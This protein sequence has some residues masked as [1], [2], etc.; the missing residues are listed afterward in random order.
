MTKSSRMTTA[1]HIHCCN[2][3][4]HNVEI[5]TREKL[6]KNR[7]ISS[8]I[9][10]TRDIFLIPNMDCPME[11][12]LIRKKLSGI[13]GINSLEFN[14]MQR[15]LTVEHETGLR[16]EIIAALK[17]I[18]MEPHETDKRGSVIQ[19]AAVPWKRLVL[20]GIMAFFS[21]ICDLLNGWSGY[22]SQLKFVGHNTMDILAFIL[23]IISIMLAGLSTY[24]K[25]WV[26]LSN[27]KL[28][29]NALMAVA[30]TGALLIGQFPEAAMVMVLFNISEGIEALSLNRARRAIKNLVDLAPKIMTIK[31]NDG[32]WVEMPVTQVELNTVARV[33]PGEKIGLDGTILSGQSQI[34]QAPITGESMPVE[35]SPGDAV[36][37]GTINETGSF[38]YRVTAVDSDTTLARII[39]AVEE[40]Q[41]VKA[42]M[43][44][45]VDI[46]AQYYTPCVFIL[47]ALCAIIPPLFF[48]HT[49]MSSIYTGLV[50]LVIGCPCALVISTPVTVV[51]G[52]A[53]CTSNGILVKGGLYLEQARKLTSLALDKTGTI[54]KGQPEMTNF[55][56]LQDKNT[57]L[58]TSIVY[59]LA[60]LS[61]HP[62]SR[63]IARA[64][65]IS[66]A[67][68]LSH[69]N[70]EALPGLGVFAYFNNEKWLLGNARLVK[71]SGMNSKKAENLILRLEKEG[72]TVVNLIGPSGIAAVI[73]V[74]DTIRPDS[75]IAIRELARMSIETIMLTGD[76]EHTAKTI[77]R[78]AGVSAYR[79]GLLPGDKLK[80]IQ[81]L[82]KE[83]QFTGMVGDGINDSPALAAADI[84]FAMAANGTDTARETADVALMDDD[85]RK[86]PLFIKLSRKT[87]VILRE[88]IAF[89][90]G[91]KAIFFGLTLSGLATM[92]MAVFADVGAALLVVGNG[93]RAMKK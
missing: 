37:A 61:D 3:H 84:G 13:Q 51:S 18:G 2:C 71:Q 5:S 89:A 87:Q 26:A 73:G 11:E 85:L 44:R 34:N 21:E 33:R 45:F 31:N 54:T 67:A 15:R 48:N 4:Q 65:Q 78:E 8:K 25:G 36:F 16:E 57:K 1:H 6:A 92:W 93:L 55:E 66:G 58:L 41:A 75:L 53:A 88:N 81:K 23:A 17:A 72:K 39:H 74:A 77:A 22:F 80:I 63:A 9:S 28:N 7:K 38:E 12:Q 14:L 90:L 43:Q 56:I 27:L 52:M 76:N 68:I 82:R 42:P 79:S 91:I 86:I 60:K 69:T 35:K 49:W 29:I 40:A 32:V 46:F 20:A 30:V 64:E 47:A 83:G 10:D 59:S 62:V 70:F 24:R 19:E 50:L